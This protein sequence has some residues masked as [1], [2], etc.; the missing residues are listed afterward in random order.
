MNEQKNAPPAEA[1][2]PEAEPQ[3]QRIELI[4]EMKVSKKTKSMAKSVGI[5]VDVLEQIPTK[6]NDY[7]TENE[8]RWQ[9][10][11]QEL[12]TLKPFIS[13]FNQYQAK[14]AQ[15]VTSNPSSS[16]IAGS[17]SPGGIGGLFEALPLIMK[18]M[19]GGG[20]NE[21]ADLGKKALMSQINMSTAITNAVVSKIAGKATSEVADAIG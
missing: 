1:N 21:F 5:D 8:R 18:L 3:P 17:A 20:N 4:P 6:I 9:V 19:G 14:Q 11:A 2:T 10:V 12:E 7:V 13:A 16:P 15:Q